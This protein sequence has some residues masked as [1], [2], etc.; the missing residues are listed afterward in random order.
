MIFPGQTWNRFPNLTIKCH[1]QF[2]IDSMGRA[3]TNFGLNWCW[4]MVTVLLYCIWI[5]EYTTGI[6]NFDPLGNFLYKMGDVRRFTNCHFGRKINKIPKHWG[7]LERCPWKFTLLSSSLPQPFCR[8]IGCWLRGGIEWFSRWCT[9]C[10]C[11]D[12]SFCKD[13][14]FS[15]SRFQ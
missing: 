8:K 10:V 2:G 15:T 7:I 14:S 5:S 4:W 6:D 13:F 3:S 12:Y 1:E 11:L 9:V